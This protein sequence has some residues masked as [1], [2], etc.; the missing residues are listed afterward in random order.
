M[1]A[2][3][4]LTIILILFLAAPVC[5]KPYVLR[6]ETFQLAPRTIDGRLCFSLDDAE[7]RRL[8]AMTYA[9]IQF[10]STSSS[11]YVFLPGRRSFWS[12]R[13]ETVTVNGLDI[14]A[15]GLYFP[16][17]KAL[18]PQAFF[19]A[20]GL[21][22][23][24]GR[25][26]ISLSPVVTSI[27]VEGPPSPREGGGGGRGHEG[28]DKPK[29][30]EPLETRPVV[31]KFASPCKPIL[32]AGPSEAEGPASV[33]TL[34]I[35]DFAWDEE[36]CPRRLHL[37]E[38]DCE[39]VG[40]DSPGKSVILRCRLR[41][42]WDAKLRT[43]LAGSAEIVFEPRHIYSLPASEASLERVEMSMG[44][45]SDSQ[46]PERLYRFILDKATL[47]TWSVENDKVILEFPA[48]RLS[49]PQPA[50]SVAGVSELFQL[51]TSR[52]PLVH[53]ETALAPGQSIDFV[54]LKDPPH[55]L[56]LRLAPKGKYKSLESSGVATTD[57][58]LGGSAGR[59]VVI[60]PGHGG[61]DSGCQNRRLGLYEKDINLDICLRLR[62]LLE[63]RGWKVTLTRE[64]DRD[65]TYAGSPDAMELEA[66]ANVA[67]R[68]HADIFVSIHCNASHNSGARGSSVYY[69][70]DEDYALAQS[71]DVLGSAV[72][73]D[74]Q[75]V[76][77]NRF[78]VLRLTNM[79][80]ALVETA[81][82]SNPS[83]GAMLGDSRVRQA[84]AERLAWGLDRYLQSKKNYSTNR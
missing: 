6:G 11:L 62:K 3:R 21:R 77:Q 29:T 44:E 79:P 1:P 22:A 53:F 26:I 66:R 73:F 4:F 74:E 23:F 36:L 49:T 10:S 82:L 63:Q 80:A 70:K 56:L 84:I 69:Y 20:L 25:E 24:E 34:E 39:A 71:L 68:I 75:G 27:G 9:Q 12:E 2:L 46:S 54:E 47:F 60:D 17:R 76:I 55:A 81:F 67:N 43:D 45:S 7:V 13:S 58:F 30:G 37:A 52:Y 61:G 35:P 32:V 83:E 57:G 31:L 8:V 42:F 72:G 19:F 28:A 14:A 78:A 16:E 33:F 15:P 41:P 65:L 40:G 38:A 48:A 51:N 5:A 59:T 18:E 64:D 50:P